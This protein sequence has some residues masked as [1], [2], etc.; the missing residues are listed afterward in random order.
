LPNDATICASQHATSDALE[1]FRGRE[2]RG[3]RL[4]DAVVGYGLIA[5]EQ[6]C[7]VFHA[8][9]PELTNGPQVPT[10]RTNPKVSDIRGV[11]KER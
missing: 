7:S 6:A 5:T 4:G 9:S 3:H 8:S 2:R 10:D 11:L 1:A